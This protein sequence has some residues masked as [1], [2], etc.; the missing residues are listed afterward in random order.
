MIGQARILASP[1]QMAGVAATVGDG[2]WRAPRL[3]STD[4][5]AAGPAVSA[6]SSAG[7]GRSCAGS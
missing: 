1:L 7:C 4:P 3:V 5:R 2:R 6:R